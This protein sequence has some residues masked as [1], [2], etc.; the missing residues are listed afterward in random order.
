MRITK[1]RYVS[2]MRVSSVNLH[3]TF[4]VLMIQTVFPRTLH[5][6]TWLLARASA[7]AYGISRG[8]HTVQSKPSVSGGRAR[9]SPSHS[10]G[11]NFKRDK[12]GRNVNCRNQSSFRYC[13]TIAHSMSAAPATKTHD[14]YRLPLDVKPTH[15]DLTI[16]T[17]LEKLTF[18]GFVKIQ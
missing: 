1:T 17:D 7:Q 15:Y 12:P 11:K 18:D 9:V 14:E 6:S 3:R 13:S 16:R 5:T 2:A 10:A 4:A 8:C